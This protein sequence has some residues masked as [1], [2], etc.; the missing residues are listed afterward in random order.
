MTVVFSSL[1]R[2]R[3]W[4]LQRGPDSTLRILDARGVCIISDVSHFS[5]SQV[6]N[7]QS[8]THTRPLVVVNTQSREGVH[9]Y[10][11]AKTNCIEMHLT[12]FLSDSPEIRFETAT[13]HTESVEVV[14]EALI[15]QF[16]LPVSELILKS[17]QLAGGKL[18]GDYW[19]ARQGAMFGK[20]RG[21][22]KCC[23]W[24][25]S[26]SQRFQAASFI[27]PSMNGTPSMTWV[28]SL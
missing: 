6:S 24:Q 26:A 18:E 14:Q 7:G 28:M 23:G 1:F 19:L 8:A 25:E 13:T 20:G 11:S 16:E 5:E 3:Y 4:E 27:S 12:V 10:A 21:I 22:V 9:V 17:A 2:N 15:F